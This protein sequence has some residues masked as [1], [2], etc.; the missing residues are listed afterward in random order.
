[1]TT[2]PW[3]RLYRSI[4]TGG[5]LEERRFIEGPSPTPTEVSLPISLDVVPSFRWKNTLKSS[6]PGLFSVLCALDRLDYLLSSYLKSPRLDIRIDVGFYG[7]SVCA[8]TP[9]YERGGW[10]SLN[11]AN[12]V[13][14]QLIRA[15]ARGDTWARARIADLYAHE[16]THNTF[17]IRGH[18]DDFYDRKKAICWTLRD[19]VEL[20][21]DPFKLVDVV[22]TFPSPSQ[23]W[24][25]FPTHCYINI[26]GA[27]S[28]TWPSS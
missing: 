17:Q 21:E 22:D 13:V 24:D 16:K 23:L 28:A 12:N 18:Q 1:M 4:N 11:L 3:F 14:E 2:K 5:F 15:V 6:F 8:S 27:A 7:C 26:K 9:L 20:T 10:V 19:V 25:L